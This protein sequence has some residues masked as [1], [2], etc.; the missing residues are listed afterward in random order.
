MRELENK[1]WKWIEKEWKF[2]LFA[3]ITMLGVIVRSSFMPYISDDFTSCLEKWFYTLKDNG[4]IFA[5]HMNIG[6]YTAPYM[7]IMAILTYLPISPLVS[8]KLVSIIFDFVLACSASK[9]VNKLLKDNKNRELFSILT[10]AVIVML[11]SVILNSACWAQCDSIYASFIVLALL[12]LLDEKYFK[13][14]VMLGISFAFKIQFVFI[15]P[16]FILVYISKRKFPFYYFFIVPITNLVMSI[17][18]IIFGK[19]ILECINV[20]IGQTQEY[21][22]WEIAM[23]SS[24]NI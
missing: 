3:I 13:S 14:F 16:L 10:Y 11:P 12:Y 17:P 24:R 6:N 4:G 21:A 20:Y 8:I 9:L 7:F 2:L 18:S 1:V 19:S 5:L 23:N 22:N 15:L